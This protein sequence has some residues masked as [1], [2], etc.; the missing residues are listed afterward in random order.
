MADQ[1]NTDYQNM[2]AIDLATRWFELGA[3]GEGIEATMEKLRIEEALAAKG[4]EYNAIFR[5]WIDARF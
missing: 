5:R 2:S 3:D 1:N 4:W